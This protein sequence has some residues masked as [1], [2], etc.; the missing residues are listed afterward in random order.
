MSLSLP[1]MKF[2]INDWLTSEK[3][4]LMDAPHIGSYIMLLALCW[5]EKHCTLPSDPE[6]LKKLSKWS[7][8]KWGD[9]GPVLAC[10]QPLKKTG[11]V[12]NP[13][14]YEEWRKARQQRDTYSENGQ[15]GA[16]KRWAEK[17]TPVRLPRPSAV[18]APVESHFEAFWNAY[19]KKIGKKAAQ[20]AWNKAKDKPPVADLLKAV[21]ISQQSEQWRKDN[22][23]YIPNPATW[24]NQ[25]RWTD[26]PLSNGH[27]KTHCDICQKDYHDAAAL[28]THAQIYHPKYEG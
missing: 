16:A 28:R 9:F 19:P 7:D 10:F 13:R 25:G 6:V 15:R 26:Q 22:G 27:A 4:A 20:H 12:T 5:S 23:Q 11:R 2:F 8:E 1:F 21:A 17:A 18:P 3:I 24:L 14:L